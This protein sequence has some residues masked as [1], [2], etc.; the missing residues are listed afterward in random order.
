M[1]DRRGFL[2]GL[3]AAGGC[4]L[5][6]PP[7]PAIAP[8]TWAPDRTGLP[9][10]SIRALT[11][12]TVEMTERQAVSGG[13]DKTRRLAP[14]A[15][16]VL[17]HP[18]EGLI[19][20][21]TGY[22][23]RTVADP[24][25]YPGK[26]STNLLHL[27]M[28]SPFVDRLADIGKTAADV[29]HALITHLHHDH[30]GGIED[31]PPTTTLWVSER[32]W[33]AGDTKG[34]LGVY[35]PLPYAD[36]KPKFFPFVGSGPYGPFTH[37]VDL[38]GD[39]AIIVVEAPGHTLGEV[40]VLVNRP[41]RSYLFTGDA[42]WVDRNWQEPIPAGVIPARLLFWDWKRSYEQLWR[43][44]DWAAKAPDLT[45]ISGHEPANLDR[46]PAWPATFA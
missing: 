29:R 19:L 42:A 31:L 46:L 1:L 26:L 3:A 20:I 10:V 22:G 5:Q 23:R 28:R 33:Y 9:D 25:D 39:G 43:I 35:N 32:E 17:E 11:V 16:Y 34:S 12:A 14:V 30:A 24:K 36:R 15:V 37:H 7:P 21:D 38:F 41:S 45:V 27:K 6:L 13:K 44:H 8:W 40:C 18:T 4:A 2:T